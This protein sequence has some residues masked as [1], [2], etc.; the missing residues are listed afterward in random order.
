MTSPYIHV[1]PYNDYVFGDGWDPATPVNVW[2]NGALIDPLPAADDGWHLNFGLDTAPTD[3]V[4]AEQGGWIA[5]TTV[6]DLEITSIDAE[7]GIVSGRAPEGA[8]VDIHAWA[9]DGAWATRATYAGP[10]PDG[11]PDYGYF[12]VDF[13]VDGDPDLDWGTETLP[14][15]DG[16]F[17]RA[18]IY[19]DRAAND[20]DATHH[21]QCLGECGDPGGSGGQ[22]E[23]YP[24]FDIVLAW[25]NGEFDL[26]LTVRRDGGVVYTETSA[27]GFDLQRAGFDLQ[28][29]DLVTVSDGETT[30]D[31][32]VR[33]HT[34]TSL[35]TSPDNTVSGT[36]LEGTTL[37]I[38]YN[39]TASGLSDDNIESATITVDDTEVWSYTFTN[40]IGPGVAVEVIEFDLPHSD[41]DQT[42]V[43]AYIPD[44][45]ITVVLNHG[46]V[47]GEGW[48]AGETV[49]VSVD[50]TSAE[51]MD[52]TV[53]PPAIVD[54]PGGFPWDT[55]WSTD[56]G[57]DL[58][59]GDI[60]T[61]TS[62]SESRVHEV[63]DLTLEVADVNSGFFAG[64]GPP[65]TSVLLDA[66]N[67][68]EH[69]YRWLTTTLET[70]PDP[71]YWS[72]DMSDEIGVPLAPNTSYSIK[73]FDGDGDVTQVG[74]CHECG[75][76]GG[77]GGLQVIADGLEGPHQLAFGYG[78][79]FVTDELGGTIWKIAPD[80][81]ISEFVTGLTG[82]SGIAFSPDGV[83]HVSDDDHHVVSYDTDG[84]EHLVLDPAAMPDDAAPLENPN[85]IAFDAA[86]NLF[87][88]NADDGTISKLDAD[89]VTFTRMFATGFALPQGLVVDD[90]GN[91]WV[92]DQFGNITEIDPDS[93]IP[94][95][96]VL[97][98]GNNNDGGLAFRSDEQ[99]FY[100]PSLGDDGIVLRVTAG[101]DVTVEDCLVGM[102]YPIGVAIGPDGWIYV[103]DYAAGQVLR[104]EGCGGGDPGGSPY[105]LYA[106]GMAGPYHH[107]WD[108]D[109]HLF[110][111]DENGNMVWRID[112]NTGDMT[113]FG[114]EIFGASGV[115][116][117]S[118][119]TLHVSD[120]EG[121][122][123]SLDA[124]GTLTEV[125]TGLSN[126]NAIAFDPSD[127]LYI[128]DIGTA[129]LLRLPSGGTDVEWITD[130]ID[131]PQGVVVDPDPSFVWV[132]GV[133]GTISKVF[134]GATVP[135][136][137]MGE[138]VEVID[139]GHRND[140]GL[141]YNADEQ[142]FYAPSTDNGWVIRV[143]NDG[144]GDVEECLHDL[145]YPRGVSIGPDGWI[146]VS[147]FERGEVVRAEG[148]GDPGGGP[149]PFNW[150]E[151]G[152]VLISQ[153]DGRLFVYNRNSGE[154]WEY[155]LPFSGN[156]DIQ[157]RDQ[158]TLYIAVHDE[159]HVSALDLA[160]GNVWEVFRNEANVPHPIGIA[161]H[162][163]EP[164]MY[165]SDESTGCG[166][167]T[168][169]PATCS[170]SPDSVRTRS[171]SH[172]AARPGPTGTSTSPTRANRSAESTPTEKVS[173]S[174]SSSTRRRT[175]SCPTTSSSASCSA[176]TGPS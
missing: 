74:D 46:Y 3:T 12:E 30:K 39:T 20:H 87:I 38:R 63:I 79:L 78:G 59:P 125:V 135:E 174:R 16:T 175:R 149:E 1:S 127:N 32:E 165:I 152:D 71:G 4:R 134:V 11:S 29:G 5:E 65:D 72:T 116:F 143:P 2:H 162:E 114:P 113:Q 169:T 68:F 80:G 171:Q 23:V 142:A 140:G 128:A 18:H 67:D 8:L 19:H 73:A 92:A 104:T 70:D 77:G 41:N 126:P 60:V 159:G 139:T 131:G 119:G 124:S 53:E 160:S 64:H 40:D 55:Y 17:F 100:M 93:G 157:Y 141:T 34:I 155:C 144:S 164:I 22:I 170:S 76:P 166:A 136:L 31:H 163:T 61:A 62:A 105:E 9:P 138:V 117:D 145:G 120:D 109:G 58:Q 98:T 14:L 97:A 88:A 24:E 168:R 48:P 118:T 15:D 121:R 51:D 176:T 43:V 129:E 115:A 50:D 122:V 150:F 6:L 82:P 156:Y 75:D 99:A 110:V 103:A 36:A 106:N 35:T 21:D 130:L 91:L 102:Q 42:F 172:R 44:P 161:F 85:A 154:M 37:L 66:R 153:T 133:N 25:G 107:A 52:Y 132:G 47:H 123:V 56:D 96:S 57:L 84:T 95:G 89:G 27:E 81:T 94:T 147:D 101:P 151:Q 90:S 69:L 158:N 54:W 83:L 111:A 146:Y 173:R 7:N 33:S 148:C 49:T 10:D 28:P 167:T 13:F 112:R 26:D 86:G 45:F 108:V 137:V